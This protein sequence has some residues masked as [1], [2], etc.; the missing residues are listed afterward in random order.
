MVAVFEFVC[1]NFA[2]QSVAVNAEKARGARLIAGGVLHGALDEAPFEFCERFIE[3]NAPVDHLA[4]ER[5]QLILH[6]YILR[7]PIE[8]APRKKLRRN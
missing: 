4:D 8:A 1:F 2:A 7:I 3:Q 5:F 6:D